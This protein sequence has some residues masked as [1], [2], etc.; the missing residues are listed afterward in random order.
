[1]YPP[2]F[3]AERERLITILQQDRRRLLA[4]TYLQQISSKLD[5][6]D[7]WIAAGFVRNAVWDA[8]HGYAPT[9]LHDIDVIYFDPADSESAKAVE[10]QTALQAKADWNWQVKNQALMHH[11]NQDSAYLD[12]EDAMRYWPE[13]ETAVAVR[14]GANGMDVLAPFGLSSLLAGQLT[15][16]PR[17]GLELFT[18]RLQSK[19][20]LMRWPHLR[21]L[22]GG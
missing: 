14:L 16:N 15:P 19:N 13:Q 12:C 3:A 10:A 1:M 6:S 2:S 18:A 4:L 8:L 17:R 21:I 11:R 9:P 20:W 7:S 5:L 22:G